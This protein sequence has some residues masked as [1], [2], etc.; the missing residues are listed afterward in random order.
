MGEFLGK[1]WLG[2]QIVAQEVNQSTS[3][4]QCKVLTCA[5]AGTTV[6]AA[7]L[8]L[9]RNRQQPAINGQ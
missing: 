7:G 8:M 9:R 4:V 6:P 2:I 3:G 5:L 1:T